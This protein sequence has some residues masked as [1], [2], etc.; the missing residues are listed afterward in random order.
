MTTHARILLAGATA[1]AVA[2]TLAGTAAAKPAKAPKAAKPGF[3]SVTVTTPGKSRVAPRV[4]VTG[5]GRRVVLTRSR[6]LRLAPGRYL[7][8]TPSVRTKAGTWYPF[9]ARERV[10]VAA[11]RTTRIRAGFQALVAPN[12]KPLTQANADASIKAVTPDT[13]T[14]TPALAAT[15][16]PGDIIASPPTTSAPNGFLRRVVSTSASKGAVTLATTQASLVEAVPQGTLAVEVTPEGEVVGGTM[17]PGK[18][19]KDFDVERTVFHRSVGIVNV[20]VKLVGFESLSDKRPATPEPL[21][22]C[23]PGEAPLVT[24]V[25]DARVY[26]RIQG[27]WD[28]PATFDVTAVVGAKGGITMGV[29]GSISG[30]CDFTTELPS[31]PFPMITVMLGPVPVTT[32]SRLDSQF[33]V[34]SGGDMAVD[35]TWKRTLSFEGGGHFRPTG[36]SPVGAMTNDGDVT[37]GDGTAASKKRLSGYVEASLRSTIKVYIYDTLGPTIA[38]ESYIRLAAATDPHRLDLTAGVRV[39]IGAS[40]KVVRWEMG[41]EKTL[42]DRDTLLAS[43]PL[44]S[45]GTPPGPPPADP[46]PP[47]PGP[48]LQPP[49]VAASLGS[50]HC[51]VHISGKVLCWGDNSTGQLGTGTTTPA[52]VMTPQAVPGISDAT[53]ITET[54]G[55]FCILHATGQVSCWGSNTAGQLGVGDLSPR[56][57]PTPVLDLV[58]AVAISG[59]KDV[60]NVCA[61]RRDRTAVC[62]GSNSYGQ[63]GDDTLITRARPSPVA[64]LTSVRSIAAGW[65]SCATLLDGTAWCWGGDRERALT[66][67]Q[68]LPTTDAVKVVISGSTY[69]VVCV[70]TERGTV[71]C[72]GAG[73]TYG[74]LG[75]GSHVYTYYQTVLQPVSTSESFTGLWSNGYA[76]S[77]ISPSGRLWQWGSAVRAL[78]ADS[79]TWDLDRPT[80]S[81]FVEKVSQFA[82]PVLTHPDGTVTFCGSATYTSSGAGQTCR[83]VPGLNILW[84]SPVTG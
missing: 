80:R 7:L 44:G 38:P 39:I 75:N 20:P 78:F 50:S 9:K 27:S 3:L 19:S 4:I 84:E 57:A 68:L 82:G 55:G 18:T 56:L 29:K 25:L 83:P 73:H 17:S 69:L 5:K 54:M 53:S 35:A 43:W 67:R 24:G 47:P 8:T 51:V 10:T 48:P 62:W 59:S 77:G 65:R 31:V 32:S 72:A 2:S 41:V 60:Q 74:H 13:V 61:I 49:S 6:T 52:L 81:N 11:K 1:L 66:P 64:N 28:S 21:S 33:A 26:Y 36:V 15:V 46:P 63:I 22:P 71:E 16:S 58:D 12:V 37:T 42:F 23:L 14:V 45:D 70:L 30:S 76:V 79:T 34:S 40:L